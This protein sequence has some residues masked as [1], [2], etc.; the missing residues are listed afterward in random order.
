MKAYIEVYKNGCV[1]KI[2]SNNDTVINRYEIENNNVRLEV[3]RNSVMPAPV[4]GIYVDNPTA[5]LN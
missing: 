1:I 5:H 4:R 3:D 2:C